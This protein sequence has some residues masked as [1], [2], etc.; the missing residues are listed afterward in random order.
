MRASNFSI[1]VSS[2]AY[3]LASCVVGCRQLLAVVAVCGATLLP[4]LLHAQPAT[5]DKVVAIVN[6]DVVLRSEYDERWKQLQQQLQQQLAQ[7][8]GQQLP[9]EDVL[10]QQVL[11]A[12]VLENLQLQLAKRV[13]VRIDDNQLN[14]AINYYAEQSKQTFEQF[15][16]LLQQQ[17][18]YEATR[19]AIRKQYI[20]ENFRYNAVNRRID[21]SKQE[22]ENYIRS[23]AGTAAIAPEYH[24]ATILIPGST[25]PTS[26][27][28]QLAQLLYQQIRDGANIL[29]FAASQQISGMQ[30]SGG[31]LGWRK[32]E[33]LPTVFVDIVPK[34]SAGEIAEPFTSSSGFHIVKLLETRGGADLKQ[35]QYLV[36][37]VL[38]K[39]N[40][41][42]TEQQ[43]EA[44]ARQLY[45]RIKDGEDFG[46][47]A[48]RNTDDPNSMVSGGDLDWIADGMLPDDFMAKIKEVPLNTVVEPFRVST[49][50][51][52]VEVRDQRLQDVTEENKR[53]Q[54]ERIL[55]ERKF[56]NELENWLTEIKDTNYIDIKEENLKD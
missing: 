52:I 42:R 55:R 54:A 31:D 33:D 45:Q 21:I 30:V 48:R 5:V 2:L 17:G 1:V 10:R 27:Q 34:L 4:S 16:Q 22:I 47:I 43:A 49:G 36:R 41:I 25:D 56:D 26:R 11:D 39:P 24:I 38:I 46:D 15:T 23:E 28:G 12:L 37:H 8:P 53:R 6:E 40:E 19:E 20:L 35:Q 18:I 14:Q 50:W 7:Q 13:G 44:L 32:F 29:Q 3:S 51:H 9:P